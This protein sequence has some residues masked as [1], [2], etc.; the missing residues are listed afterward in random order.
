MYE[1]L[2]Y[3]FAL[4]ELLGNLRYEP[5]ESGIRRVLKC[6][7]DKIWGLACLICLNRLCF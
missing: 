3:Y 7:V 5:D 4:A 6:M 1:S 2:G